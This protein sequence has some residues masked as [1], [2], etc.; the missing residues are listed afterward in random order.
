MA[1]RNCAEQLAEPLKMLGERRD[2][3]SQTM[4]KSQFG[5]ID[6]AIATAVKT[7]GPEFV[8]KCIPITNESGEININR[9]W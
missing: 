5:Q 8:L 4:V 7:M 9:T 6:H 3:L 2:P 1:G